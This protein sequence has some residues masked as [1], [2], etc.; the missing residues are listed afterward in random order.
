MHALN[1]WI[2]RVLVAAVLG[3]PAGVAAAAEPRTALPEAAPE[4]LP[5]LGEALRLPNPYR[6]LPAAVAAGEQAY[7]R[8]C[9]VCHGAGA[10]QPSA[11]APELRRLDTFCRRL[12]DSAQQQRCLTDVDAYFMRSVQEGKRR[13]GLMHMPAWAGVLPQETIWAIR[14][15]TATR[16]APAP[17]TL[18]DLPPVAP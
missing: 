12:Q 7:G 18:P 11:E 17:R 3:A 15:F 13:A 8:H 5:A 2:G 10:V 9:A 4:G 6:G 14:S 1:D 16:P